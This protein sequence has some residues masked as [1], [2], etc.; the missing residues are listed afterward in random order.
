MQQPEQKAEQITALTHEIRMFCIQYQ[1]LEAA[2]QEAKQ[3]L[4]EERLLSGKA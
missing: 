4:S 2:D 1:L 3:T